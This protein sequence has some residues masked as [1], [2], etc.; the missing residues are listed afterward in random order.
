MF[1]TS[2]HFSNVNFCDSLE[3]SLASLSTPLCPV[4]HS[5]G[6]AACFEFV[7]RGWYQ[8]Q[9]ASYYEI[10]EAFVQ[11]LVRI[12]PSSDSHNLKYSGKPTHRPQSEIFTISIKDPSP[13]CLDFLLLLFNEKAVVLLCAENF[14]GS[15]VC[16]HRNLTATGF[17]SFL[18]KVLFWVDLFTLIS[19]AANNR[20]YI[21]TLR[22]WRHPKKSP[23]QP[24]KPLWMAKAFG[25]G[26][27][28]KDFPPH[29][30]SFIF[31]ILYTNSEKG[32]GVK[33]RGEKMGILCYSFL[34]FIYSRGVW[35]FTVTRR[36]CLF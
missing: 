24:R 15:L 27:S 34:I 8:K 23:W 14:C 9:L 1:H 6:Q 16:P 4:S 18:L 25:T 28:S 13:W 17:P 35:V 33:E 26:L 29:T 19:H 36:K 10:A 22:Y 2:L 30:L 20:S 12:S 3:K 21:W 7:G 31:S 11:F 5:M 32:P